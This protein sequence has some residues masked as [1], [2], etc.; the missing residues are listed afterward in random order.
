MSTAKK[1]GRSKPKNYGRGKFC[2]F[3]DGGKKV[4]CY[5]KEATAEKVAKAFT[6]NPRISIKYHVRTK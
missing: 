5:E 2:V 1:T 4:R 6:R 3:T